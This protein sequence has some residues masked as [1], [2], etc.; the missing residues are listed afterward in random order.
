MSR[1]VHDAI[2]TAIRA[3]GGDVSFAT[4]MEL[5]LYGPG[6][7]YERPPVGPHG[8]FVTA[9]HVHPVFGRLLARALLDCR[10]ALGRPEPFR[11]TEVGAGDG[12]LARQVIEALG[13]VPLAYTAVDRSTGALEALSRLEGLASA[14]VPPRG[15]HLLLANELLDNL[16]FRRVRM[17]QVGPVEVRVGESD[18]HLVERLVPADDELRR[19]IGNLPAGEET[20]VPEGALAFVDGLPGW[21][22]IAGYVLVID[23]G[24][25]GTPG[26]ITH[27]Y[28]SH[29][30]VEDPLDAPGET[31]I[32][33]GVDL[34]MIASR[35]E[36]I[37]LHAF[38]SV[39]QR[40]AL[41]ALG[42]DGWAREELARQHASLDA[43]DGAA[44]VGAWSDRSR[45]TLL[46]DP[47][48]LGRFRWL[49]LATRGLP[50]PPWLDA[51]LETSSS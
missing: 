24:G 5:A 31:D 49:V 42:F 37:G 38:P 45:A 2:V 39:T 18:G 7:Y 27:G 23:Y 6:G 8:D 43:R 21:M 34:A 15:A 33:A 40:E 44:A 11:I 28:R 30:V 32:T 12:T 20:V 19:A 14:T 46:V 9:P 13:D 47:G 25:L 51:A 50:A 1:R 10:E 41:S 26:G 22:D 29:T 17:A 3:A 4:Y 35:A 16:P 48:A 36:A